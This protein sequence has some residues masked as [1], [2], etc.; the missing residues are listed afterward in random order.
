MRHS[1]FW[2]LAEDE[3]GSAYARTIVRDQVLEA[4]G[5]RTSEQ[6][7]SAGVRPREVWVALCDAMDVP[8]QRRWGRDA[9]DRH[10][11]R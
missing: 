5:G 6:A 10:R 8:D 1:E 7:L 9:K 2:Q 4:L 11:A 3:F